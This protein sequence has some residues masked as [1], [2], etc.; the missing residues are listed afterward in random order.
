M[1][2]CTVLKDNPIAAFTGHSNS[3]FYVKSAISPDDNYLLSGSSDNDAY[4]WNVKTP[5][6]APMVLKGHTKEVTS[7]DWCTVDVGKVCTKQL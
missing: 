2:E 4:L 7:V 6:A 3:T 1:Y 5:Q